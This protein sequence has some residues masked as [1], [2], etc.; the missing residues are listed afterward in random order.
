MTDSERVP[1]GDI[2]KR[3]WTDGSSLEKLALTHWDRD[4]IA[5]HLEEREG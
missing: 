1:E 5:T 2:F 3:E 4:M